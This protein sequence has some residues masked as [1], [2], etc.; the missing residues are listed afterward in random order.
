VSLPAT[1]FDLD[2]LAQADNLADWAFAQFQDLVGDHVV[3][4]GPGLGTFSQRVLDSG[5][6]S[7]LLVEPERA[8]HDALAERYR[9][10]ARVT[11]VQE[12]VPGSPT[13]AAA[14]PSADFVLC[15]NV[16]EHIAD[17]HGAV[18]AMADA[19][20]PGG[21]LGLL[22]PAHPRLYGS[23]DEAFGHHRRYTRERLGEVVG[24]AGLELVDLYSFN[25]L[26]VAG[27]WVKGRSG[28]GGL[29]AGSLA[30]Y[31]RLVQGWRHLE[32]WRRPP[33]GLSLIA[34]ARKPDV[35]AASP[36]SL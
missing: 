24:V 29:G 13:L 31:E 35:A 2:E 12:A 6:S 32:G 8:F 20:R 25:L 10:E 3:E 34:R 5:A 30:A 36:L 26:G 17:D 15:Q 21:H 27:W 22:V 18:R 4:V 19:L 23:L 11:L 14:G 1:A 9:D 28:A 33:W 16:I 7:V